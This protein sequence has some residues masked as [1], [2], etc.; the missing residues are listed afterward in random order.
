MKGERVSIRFI[1]WAMLALAGAYLLTFG[2][3]IPQFG[4]D[5][6]VTSAALWALVAAASFGSATVLGKQLLSSLDFVDATFARYGMTTL[7]ALI[8]LAVSG[9]A[10]PFSAITTGNWV[11]ILIIALTSGSGAIFLYYK[12]LKSIPASVATICELCLPL[13][14]VVFDWI[15]N[16][17]LLGPWQWAGVAILV[18]SI[19]RIS[20]RRI[21]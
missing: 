7:F 3:S 8:Y 17:S 11:V 16:G 15:A 1:R 20:L 13:S 14:A 12:G 18:G 6:N 5:A 2:V 19:L 4:S 10:M 21:E 9:G